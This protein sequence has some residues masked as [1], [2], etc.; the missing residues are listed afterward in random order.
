[1]PLQRFRSILQTLVDHRV[2][3]IVIGGVSAV[4]N[5]A[6]LNTLDVDV[7]HSTSAENV[8]KLLSALRELDAYYRIQPERRI[9][10]DASHLSSGG[11]HLLLTK[12]GP[13]DFLGTV[14][15]QRAY[16]DLLP[17]STE[18][19]LDPTL[20]IR[21]LNLE[22][23]I[24]LKEESTQDKDRAV[25]PVLRRTLEEIQ[26]RERQTKSDVTGEK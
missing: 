5:G 3:F 1:M 4:L 13:A 25:L 2:D 24:V 17:F 11:H 16:A 19:V 8:E 23:L 7:V 12:F 10:P 20:A 9:R 22:M 15:K 14:S 21:V 26:R 6:P 18:L